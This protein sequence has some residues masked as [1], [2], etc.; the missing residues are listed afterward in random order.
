MPPSLMASQ[1]ATL[2]PPG[3]EERAIILSV[4]PRPEVIVAA[5]LAALARG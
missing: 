5:A 4:A 3:P 1:F 2:E